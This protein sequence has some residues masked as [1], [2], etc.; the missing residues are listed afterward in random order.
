MMVDVVLVVDKLM[1]VERDKADEI[2][3]I[4]VNQMPIRKKSIT[5]ILMK[6]GEFELFQSLRCS[7]MIYNMSPIQHLHML[8]Y[9]DRKYIPSTCLAM[10]NPSREIIYA[11]KSGRSGERSSS[12]RIRNGRAVW[13]SEVKSRFVKRCETAHRLAPDRC[14]MCTEQTCKQN[15]KMKDIPYGRRSIRGQIQCVTDPEANPVILENNR[16]EEK[17]CEIKSE[18]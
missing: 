1:I 13:V 18:I 17:L 16:E 5:E 3:G 8:Y 4:T 7:G 14:R 9:Y 12:E 6:H 11:V 15:V 10:L 2:Q